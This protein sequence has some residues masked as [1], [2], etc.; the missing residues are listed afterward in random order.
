MFFIARAAMSV[1][2][3]TSPSPSRPNRD[4]SDF[5]RRASIGIARKP[6]STH[7]LKPQDHGL[8]HSTVA[9][10]TPREREPLLAASRIPPV[11]T[12]VAQQVR[13]PRH[14]PSSADARDDAV[15]NVGTEQAPVR[16]LGAQ[17]RRNESSIRQRDRGRPSPSAVQ[18]RASGLLIASSPQAFD[19]AGDERSKTHQGCSL[20]KMH[21][22][23]LVIPVA[24]GVRPR[25]SR[26][27]SREVQHVSTGEPGVADVVAPNDGIGVPARP[28]TMVAAT[29]SV[30]AACRNPG[31]ARCGANL[32]FTRRPVTA[33][34]VALVETSAALRG[35]PRQWSSPRARRHP[36]SDCRNR[37]VAASDAAG[38]SRTRHQVP[39]ASCTTAPYA[40]SAV[41]GVSDRWQRGVDRAPCPSPRVP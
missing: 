6:L 9:V 13:R 27:E 39:A 33:D 35:N 14:T 21:G 2:R 38:R 30:V 15:A 10:E 3:P 28:R 24:R 16:A 5:G 22:G 8:T 34:A 20:Q 18:Y 11:R 17:R 12:L 25:R 40:R 29:Y 41:S 1:A 23:P 32:P 37:S 4:G 26:I 19:A 7:S 31:L 36:W